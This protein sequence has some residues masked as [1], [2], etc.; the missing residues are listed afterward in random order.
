MTKRNATTEEH[1]ELAGAGAHS[2][3]ADGGSRRRRSSYFPAILLFL[4][5][6][7]GGS[8]SRAPV[9]P[10][11]LELL[12]LAIFITCLF[13]YRNRAVDP[14]A[15][16]ALALLGLIALTPLLQLVPLPPEIW[17]SLP[18]RDWV[19]DVTSLIGTPDIWLPISLDPDATIATSLEMI[20]AIVLFLLTLAATDRERDWMLRTIIA[21][22][23]ISTV[24][25]VLQLAGGSQS[26][27]YPFQT[28][29]DEYPVGLFTN[30]NHQADFLVI[31]V[32]MCAAAASPHRPRPS[33]APAVA[34]G[35]I[36]L[37]SIAV[38]A[39]NSRTG[40][41]LL[42]GALLIS[43]TFYFD[44]KRELRRR[45]RV[46]AGLFAT[47]GV[48]A[49][50]VLGS[51]VGQ[52]GIERFGDLDDAR[53]H[54]WPDVL[55]AIQHYFP[56]GS[57]I[58]TF[59]PVY[60]S[61]EQLDN[62]SPFYVNHAHSDYLEILL[63]TGAWGALLVA[64]FFVILYR[65]LRGAAASRAEVVRRT[66]GWAILVLLAHSAVDYPLRSTSLL[67]VFGVLAGLLYSSWRPEPRPH[68]I[69]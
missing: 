67:A 19:G 28:T 63:E 35:L 24:L 27:F 1:A 20:P 59:V 56:V 9:L 16:P 14:S 12:A 66:A 6:L 62:L 42:I 30:R 33:L 47:A 5:L 37:F 3:S 32:L 22:G 55:V 68:T 50:L 40:L 51:A 34:W 7:L 29:H 54:F 58:G 44:L 41:L 60:K 46:I 13:R 52:R 11:A 2:A 8:G 18:G 57:G 65:R 25:G 17:R 53:F 61:F 15:K 36:F 26:I 49:L 45:W 23:L 31:A 21:A 10:I 38:V 43:C 48:I 39:T 64:G 69:R 4:C